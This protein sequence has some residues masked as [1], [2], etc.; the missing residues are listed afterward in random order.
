MARGI[1]RPV[2]EVMSRILTLAVRMYGVDTYVRFAFSP[3][4]LRPEDE[5]E[6]F[7]TMHQA[8]ILEQLSEGF[9]TDEE[10]AQ[11]LGTGPRAP[12][13]PPL[14][15]TGFMRGNSGIDATKASPNS[16]PQGRALQSG[17]PQKAGGKSQ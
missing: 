11:A 17:S 7:K 12:G 2:E 15:G 4:N 10:A 13:A 16:D 3:I 14:S 9:L 6:A 5:L 8:R 1:Q